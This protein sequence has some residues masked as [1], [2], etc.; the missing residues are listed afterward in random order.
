MV[1]LGAPAKGELALN[2]W[3]HGAQGLISMTGLS[4]LARTCSVRLHRG[5]AVVQHE[6]EVEVGRRG[7]MEQREELEEV[8]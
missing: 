1:V 2:S 3:E 4:V 8:P 7:M 5:L 6:A